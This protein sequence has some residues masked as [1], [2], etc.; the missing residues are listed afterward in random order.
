MHTRTHYGANTFDTNK[1]RPSCTLFTL[2]PQAGPGY[3]LPR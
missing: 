1:P 2:S 3:D